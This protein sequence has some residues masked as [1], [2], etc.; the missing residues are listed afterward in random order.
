MT[1]DASDTAVAVTLFRV[2]K[3]DAATV[4]KDDL[5]DPT[6]AQIIGISYK[7]L[8]KAQLKWLTF[9]AELYAI[10]IGCTKFGSYITTATAQYPPKGVK[11]IALWSDSTTALSQWSHLTL[12]SAV[13]EH[14]SAKARRFFSWAD[15]VAYTRYWPI[16][17]HHLPGEENDISHILS[18]LGE[19][20]RQRHN[21]LQDLEASTAT[22]AATYCAH[23]FPVQHSFHEPTPAKDPLAG[24][25]IVHLNLKPADI[26]EIQRAYLQDHTL[27]NEIPL[28][29]IYKIVTGHSDAKAVPHLHAKQVKAWAHRRFFSVP[30]QHGPLLF[31]P[32]SCTVNKY[33]DGGDSP[34]R[35]KHL[36]TVVPKGAQVRITTAQPV[37]DGHASG[38]HWADHDMRRDILIHCHD[39]SNHPRLADTSQRVRALVW[40]PKMRRYI[41]YH[42]DSCAYCVAKRKATTPVGSSVRAKRRLKLIEFDHKFLEPQVVDA[43]GHA[44]VLT[45]V[46]TVS[47]VTM[48]IPVK[49]KDAVCTARALFTQWYP[50]FG[51]PAVFRKD[52]AAEY[53]SEVMTAFANMLG[54]KHIDTSCPDNPTHHSMV[55]RRNKV[56]EKFIDVAISKGDIRCAE[57]LQM[58][59]ATAAAACNLEY[60]YNGH[61][62]LEYLTGEIPRTQRD[63][64]TR[65]AADLSGIGQDQLGSDFVHRLRDMLHEH[66]D[67]VSMIRD[68]DARHNTLLRDA[69]QQGRQVTQFTLLPGDR[70]SYDGD[71]YQLL[72]VI[73]L[74][75][76]IPTKAVV[77]TVTHDNATS[78][79]VKYGDLRPLTDPRP[80]NMHRNNNPTVDSADV[81][82]FVFYSSANSQK[83]HSGLITAKL[84]ARKYTVHQ[85]AQAQK[86][87][88]RFTPLYYNSQTK[89]N[90]CKV[91]PQTVHSPVLS[92]INL[93]DI[94]VVGSISNTYHVTPSL[95]DAVRSVGVADNP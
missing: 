33:P 17:A 91:K 72:E 32:S 12:P 68:D 74:H 89:K 90:E 69:Q 34:D 44:A 48:F 71:E 85:Y 45:I 47:R 36:V 25:D 83:V 70:V 41:D 16:V 3:S 95:L 82:D 27:V 19:E 79:T 42:V 5:A 78:K 67:I 7:K 18:H 86:Q 87:E 63:T 80:V 65:F 94:T 26:K 24:F 46:D 35:T 76:D 58:Y 73:Y 38:D 9:E 50:L 2:N 49:S 93:S 54:V 52:K 30:T 84:D 81:G 66:N 28:S 62:V 88:T 43:T 57:D 40:F 75:D 51:V 14:L 8:T 21:Y 53:S 11:K 56:M 4:T 10:V 13:T 37:V 15:K 23:V 60:V 6:V 61:T 55:E 22:V 92:D 77:R 59:C 20:T 31:A 29:D 1:T 64:A 39:N